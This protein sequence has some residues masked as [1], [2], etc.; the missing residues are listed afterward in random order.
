MK[1]AE[2]QR[3]KAMPPS[4][5]DVAAQLSDI[6]ARQ[7]IQE[8]M[9]FC[10]ELR[11]VPRWYATNSFNIKFKGKVVCRFSMHGNLDLYL[12]V[13]SARS[14]LE[15]ALENMAPE[16][17]QLYF[18]HMRR[19]KQCSPTHQSTSLTLFGVTYDKLCGIGEMSLR[20]PHKELLP[21]LQAFILW[22]RAYIQTRSVHNL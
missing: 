18:T 7:L 10:A 22:R 5:D 8:L 4:F 2:T 16:L 12:P 17:R 15:S 3:Q 1:N 13:E 14:A 6:E 9:A 20:N 11:M 19:C 21:S